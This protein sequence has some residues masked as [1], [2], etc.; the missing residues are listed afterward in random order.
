MQFVTEKKILE[1]LL[2]AIDSA[3]SGDRVDLAMFYLSH[4]RVV[5]A[6]VDADGRGASVRLVL[7]PN[8]DAFG[9]E[10][11]GIPN[12]QVAHELVA[13]SDGGIQVRWYDTHG[14]QFHT[15]LVM[16]TRGDSVVVL[17]G[18]PTSPAGISATSTWRRTSGLSLPG[19]APLAR[20]VGDYF[21]T[22]FANQG[23]VH[24][25]LRGIPG[26]LPPETDP[27]PGGGVHGVLLVLRP[28][29]S[30]NHFWPLA[31]PS[32]AGRFPGWLASRG[33][34]TW[35]ETPSASPTQGF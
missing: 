8:K 14:E 6:L 34:R 5:E 29:R 19:E 20:S 10:K 9:R 35:G 33:P 23:G 30:G 32:P 2:E 18:P 4:R 31:S 13:R 28:E 1:A 16:V 11:G 21:E 7:D 25:S 24:S 27:L 12:R 15:K 26:R 3:G 22:V 17:G